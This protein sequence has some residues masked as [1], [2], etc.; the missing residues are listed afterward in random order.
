MPE[1][2]FRLHSA[3]KRKRNWVR[4]KYLGFLEGKRRLILN[5][6]KYHNFTKYTKHDMWCMTSLPLHVFSTPPMSKCISF[7]VL[8]PPTLW[9]SGTQTKKLFYG[10]MNTQYCRPATTEELRQ[11][12]ASNVYPSY[13]QLVW[14]VRKNKSA[15]LYY[16]SILN[17]TLP[18]EFLVFCRNKTIQS[19]ISERNGDSH[20]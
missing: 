4:E 18:T 20:L 13:E 15:N 2:H 3:Q 9:S 14:E 19:T 1:A 7:I 12:E 8:T 16:N 17:C 11:S 10:Y 5:L 6:S